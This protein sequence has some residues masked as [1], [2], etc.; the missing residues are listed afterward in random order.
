M[1][2]VTEVGVVVQMKTFRSPT[3]IGMARVIGDLS[4]YA[5]PSSS[6]PVSIAMTT[7]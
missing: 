6:R 5:V 3:V 7:V 1:G 4:L 2:V